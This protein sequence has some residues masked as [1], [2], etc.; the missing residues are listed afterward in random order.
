MS[1]HPSSILHSWST[2]D[3]LLH[4]GRPCE[5]PIC[6]AIIPGKRL[7]VVGLVHS[8]STVKQMLTYDNLSSLTAYFTSVRVHG[9]LFLTKPDLE[10]F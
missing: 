7:P 1:L 6:T 5:A 4:K 10:L 2:S 9:A 8:G 3:V